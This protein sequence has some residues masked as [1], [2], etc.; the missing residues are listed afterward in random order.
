[1]VSYL[2]HLTFGMQIDQIVSPWGK[3]LLTGLS[4]SWDFGTVNVSL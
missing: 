4:A 2:V 3:H 1:V